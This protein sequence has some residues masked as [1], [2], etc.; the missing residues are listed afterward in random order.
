M[1][2]WQRLA[3]GAS[4]ALLLFGSSLVTSPS[5][6]SNSQP[7]RASAADVMACSV[8]GRGA[9]TS[10]DVLSCASPEPDTGPAAG[11]PGGTAPESFEKGPGDDYV[12]LYGEPQAPARPAGCTTPVRG[13]YTHDAG[14]VTGLRQSNGRP[15]REVAFHTHYVSGFGEGGR[16]LIA[17]DLWPDVAR[18]DTVVVGRELFEG[19]INGRTGSAI[20]WNYARVD[21]TGRYIGRAIAIGGTEGLKNLRFQANF[22]GFAPKGGHWTDP[23]YVCF[24]D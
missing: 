12:G 20:I 17:G 4:G 7:D 3:A 5:G 1:K 9:L 2:G 10:G 23:S 19:T 18:G 15:V 13:T 11:V 14:L 6:A 24:A 8:T 16:S 21:A 22:T